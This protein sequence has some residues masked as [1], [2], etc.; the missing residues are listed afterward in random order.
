[1]K[2]TVDV[3]PR[4]LR[5]QYVP[6][7]RLVALAF[8]RKSPP[9]R[10]GNH[11]AP[12]LKPVMVGSRV[13][14]LAR[15]ASAPVAATVDR[16]DWETP[17]DRTRW[18]F[19]ETLTP[20]YYTRIYREL[21]LEHRRRYNQ[22]TGMLANE[23]ISVL[24]TEFLQASLH[25]VA[26]TRGDPDL[27]A[28]VQRF[29]EDERRH[30]DIWLT[31]NR[32]SE[33]AWYAS[34]TRRFVCMPAYARVA[35]RVIARHPLAF[36]VVFWLQLAQEERSIEISRRCMRVAAERIE[37][38]YAAAYA[39][40]LPDEIRHVQIDRYLIERFYDSRSAMIRATTARLFKAVMARFLLT[41]VD[42]T[43][44]V[45]STLAAEFFELRPLVPRMRRELRELE[46]DDEYHEMMYSRRTTPNTFAL[47]D[48]FEE[49][50]QMRHVL[51]AY[52]PLPVRR[53]AS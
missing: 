36:P 19:C 29:K 17:I 28:A 8:G 15:L 41:P 7:I 38:R 45:I 32:L 44:R 23:I 50:H 34:K 46:K 53:R 21:S 1:M 30:A 35:S 10:A 48:R 27:L 6:L 5:L 26:S 40:H 4:S 24:E 2:H 22:L 13:P 31:L 20:L 47:F 9:P 11:D 51:R 43:A 14:P 25:A 37:P 16:I 39:A 3:W 52:Q 12:D 49:F 18:F 33:P 42:S